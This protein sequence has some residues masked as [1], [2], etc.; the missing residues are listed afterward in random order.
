MA[1]FTI[2]LRQVG[3]PTSS[4]PARQYDEALDGITGILADA[5]E[6]L[7][8]GGHTQFIVRGFGQDP[9]PVKTSRDLAIF[10]EGMPQAIGALRRGEAASLGFWT[11]GIERVLDMTPHAGQFIVECRSMTAWEPNPALINIPRE[12]MLSMLDRFLTSFVSQV[13][14]RCPDLVTHPWFQSWLA[15]A[16]RKS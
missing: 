3:R 4:T 1:E 2:E 7:A 8:D 14:Q 6:A 16:S 5:C 11:Q 15:R 10:I 12:E 9:W 13:R